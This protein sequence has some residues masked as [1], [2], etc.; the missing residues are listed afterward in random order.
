MEVEQPTYAESNIAALERLTDWAK[1]PTVTELKE[2]LTKAKVT[3]AT[4]LSRVDGWLDALNA[5]GTHKVP[6]VSGRS[7]VQPKLVRKQAEWR[8]T[9]MSEPFLSSDKVFTVKPR[10]HEDG[11]AAEQMELLL[12]WQMDCYLNKVVFIDQF[13]RRAADEGTVAIMTGWCREEEEVMVEAPVMTYTRNFD[14]EYAQ[15]L[16]QLA[17]AGPEIHA[18]TDPIQ[19]AALRYS[20]EKRAPFTAVQTGVQ[21]VKQTKLVRNHPTVEVIN[22]RN[23]LVDPSCGEDYENAGFISYSIDMSYSDM[24]K[25]K[26]FKNVDALNWNAVGPLAAPD[27][28][29]KG[30]QDFSFQDKARQTKTVVFYWGKRDITGDGKLTPVLCAW[31]DNIMVRCETTPF[32]DK[33]PPIVL[34]PMLPIKGSPFGESDAELLDNNQRIIGAVIRGMI[35]LMARSANAQRGTAKNMLDT[36]NRRRFESGMDYE[37]NPGAHPANSMIEHKFPEIP[38][39]AM[40]MVN[41]FSA[42]SESLTGV[43]TFDDGLTGASLGPTAAGAKGVLGAASRREMG[44]LRRLAY[45]LAKVGKKIAAMNQEFLSEEEVVRVTND[46]FVKINP[47]NIQGVFDFTVEIATTDED[48]ARAGR[49]EFMLQTLGNNVDFGITKMLL[50]EVAKLRRMPALAHQLKNFQPEPD[51]LVVQEQQLKI[52]LLQ[53]QV[54]QAEAAAAENEAQADYHRARAELARAQ[55]DMTDLNYVE[56]ETGTTHARNV[57]KVGAQARANTELKITDAILNQSNGNNAEGKETTAPRR[58]DIVDA[59]RYNQG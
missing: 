18:Q 30:P 40:G 15:A 45:G 54:R 43:K 5:T 10:T 7:T 11:P 3:H 12:N 21:K 53:A 31:V 32:P 8:Y 25:D 14:P 19:M 52:A 37:F 9:A 58:Q 59:V 47:D 29:P 51:P 34:I 22:I 6:K 24:I 28:T 13:V 1:E 48:E 57:D 38:N 44:I 20:V 33:K 26:R 56:Q 35:D 4:H 17:A 55:K 49:L 50:A 16:E 46:K 39:S 23:L 36:V 42:D 41:M 27:H 2:D